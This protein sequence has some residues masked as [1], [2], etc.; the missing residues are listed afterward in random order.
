M[1]LRVHH[2]LRSGRLLFAAAPALSL[3][4]LSS[5]A[6]ASAEGPGSYVGWKACSGCHQKVTSDWRKGRHAGA[7]ADLAKSGQENL[8][9]CV[10]C[11]VTGHDRPAGF[12]DGEVT[13]G[14]AGVQCEACHGPGMIHAASPG[15][16]AILRAPGVETCRRC[17]TPG[18]DPGFDYAKKAAGVHA[19][20]AAPVRAAEGSGLAALPDHFNFDAVDEGVPASTTVIV[21]NTG[22]R[23]ISITHVRT[24]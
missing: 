3:L 23:E 20:V 21:Q 18:Q 10:R 11:H 16:G 2:M 13:P 24:S 7:F 17:H 5:P 22:D 12:V 8:P 14:L 1:A 19:P 6:G 9:A 15:T 4:L